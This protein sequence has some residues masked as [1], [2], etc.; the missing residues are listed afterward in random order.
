MKTKIRVFNFSPEA[1]M[2]IKGLISWKEYRERAK[3]T[4]AKRKNLKECV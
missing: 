2:Y 4:K 1:R 3:W